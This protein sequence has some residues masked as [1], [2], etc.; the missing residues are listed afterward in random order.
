MSHQLEILFHLL[1]HSILCSLR[2]PVLFVM[3]STPYLLFTLI[4]V[5]LV[6]QS[7][8]TIT[9]PCGLAAVFGQGNS[10]VAELVSFSLDTQNYSYTSF[11]ASYL[12]AEVTQYFV[13]D[14]STLY[15]FASDSAIA[16]NAATNQV[17][18]YPQWRTPQ[19]LQGHTLYAFQVISYDRN[20]RIMYGIQLLNMSSNTTVLYVQHGASW[21]ALAQLTVPPE[22]G[23]YISGYSLQ[24]VLS[25]DASTVVFAVWSQVNM[26]L[27]MITSFNLVTKS[28]SKQV[29]LQLQ[30]R[31]GNLE[32]AYGGNALLML[33]PS[34][35]GPTVFAQYSLTTG[36]LI[37]SISPV[38]F[39]PSLFT[40]NYITMPG[41]NGLLAIGC[42]AEGEGCWVCQ[43]CFCRFLSCRF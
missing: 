40:N 16:V 39:Y 10:T 19:F 26:R 32:A 1:F 12:S 18:T 25:E 6:L 43:S 31:I 29:P 35:A 9:S 41:N 36:A 11:P 8:A 21:Q 3:Q 27:A 4:I 37:S 23:T 20:K 15:L 2:A 14:T 28:W 33:V 17:V 30:D 7:I 42:Q 13:S 24:A 38:Y 5:L 34:S 22:F